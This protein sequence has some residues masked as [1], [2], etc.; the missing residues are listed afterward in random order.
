MSTFVPPRPVPPMTNPAFTATLCH[1]SSFQIPATAPAMT[2]LTDTSEF[3]KQATIT[4]VNQRKHR[5]LN[6][7]FVAVAGSILYGANIQS[8]SAATNHPL[9]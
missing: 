9:A 5:D 8:I 7:A 2:V 4:Q 6:K 1:Q 3:D